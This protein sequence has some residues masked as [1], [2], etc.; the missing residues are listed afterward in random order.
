MGIS[1]TVF[2]ENK[3][4]QSPCAR[5][6]ASAF[7]FRC[8]S[9]QAQCLSRRCSKPCTDLLVFFR[10]LIISSPSLE[11]VP[12]FLLRGRHSPLLRNTPRAG[13]GCWRFQF[14]QRLEDCD[15][16]GRTGGLCSPPSSPQSTTWIITIRC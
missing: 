4:L 15:W 13:S 7:D 16:A 6:C 10:W 2:R 5:S 3:E 11:I 1:F 14:T 8:P 9:C 12:Y